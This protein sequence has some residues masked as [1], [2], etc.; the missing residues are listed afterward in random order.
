MLELLAFAEMSQN[1]HEDFVVLLDGLDLVLAESG[2]HLVLFA[3]AERRIDAAQYDRL[4]RLGGQRLDVATEPMEPVQWAVVAE[5]ALDWVLG[6]NCR[7]GERRRL[8][9]NGHGGRGR[10]RHGRWSWGLFG[11]VVREVDFI[12]SISL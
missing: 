4:A 8:A 10:R 1:G 6:G 7:H 2:E 11:A 9:E 3:F 5:H 12:G